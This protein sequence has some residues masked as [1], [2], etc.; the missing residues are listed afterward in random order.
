MKHHGDSQQTLDN[1][2][3]RWLRKCHQASSGHYAAET[4]FTVK[5]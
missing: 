5:G 3:T 1:E 2:L 4:T